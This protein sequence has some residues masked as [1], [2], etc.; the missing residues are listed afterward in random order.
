MSGVLPLYRPKLNHNHRQDATSTVFAWY[1]ALIPLWDLCLLSVVT[2][3]TKCSLDIPLNYALPAAASALAYL[4]ARWS[5]SYDAKLIGSLVKALARS[6][7]ASWNSRLNLFYMLEHHAQAPATKD[8]PMLV[9]NG[10]TWTFQEAYLT[11]MRY[12]T[13]LKTVHGV[14]PKDIVAIDFMN[15]STFIFL[16]LGLW[17]IGAVPALINYNLTGKPLTH[18]VRVSTAKLLIVD[19]EL[20][21]NFTPELM[22]TFATPGFR[23]EKGAVDV[24]FFTPDVEEQVLKTPALREED[25]VRDNV[26]L[27]DLAVLI[28]TSGTTGLPKPAIVSWLKCWLGSVF[29]G[30]WLKLS[31]DDRFF[32]VCQYP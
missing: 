14:K 1:A 16:M 12:G 8:H 26:E 31:K 7:Y 27:R 20:R 2:R 32:T 18:S 13:W 21:R 6:R 29:S 19:E 9:Y 25:N 30:N 17:S 3:L 5:I 24:L 28:Y 15:S 11:A 23:E 22:E 10:R 4:N